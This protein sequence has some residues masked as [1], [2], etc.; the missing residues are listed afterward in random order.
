MST[1]N[2][3][4]QAPHPTKDAILKRLQDLLE[5]YSKQLQPIQTSLGLRPT[6]IYDK[7][8]LSRN[9][10]RKYLKYF[11]AKGFVEFRNGRYVWVAHVRR[12]E[13]L[14]R[15][16]KHFM[17]ELEKQTRNAT[18]EEIE[19]RLN[20]TV[21]IFKPNGSTSKP[22]YALLSI[23]LKEMEKPNFGFT[24]HMFTRLFPNKKE[25]IK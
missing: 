14:N 16:Y 13:A 5:K 15:I 11:I 7:S 22:R 9:T 8:H 2:L 17:S 19:G 6:E 25:A 21:L 4:K 23:P 20:E 10:I 1:P 18:A 24:W 12:I 3:R